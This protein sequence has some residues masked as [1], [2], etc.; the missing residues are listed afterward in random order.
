MKLNLQEDEIGAG[1]ERVRDA[2]SLSS[3]LSAALG[4]YLDGTNFTL[5]S[6]Q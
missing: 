2:I 5:V 6:K 1:S 4:S 3:V